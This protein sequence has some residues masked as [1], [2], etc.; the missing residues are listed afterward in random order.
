MLARYVH[1]AGADVPLVWYVTNAV[2]TATRRYLVADRQGSIV[3]AT[4][5]AGAPL[6]VDTY[7]EYGVPGASNSGRFQY[8]G[9]AW[10]PELGMYYYKA[11]VYSPTL[12]RFMQT[13]PIGYADQVNLYAYVGDDP[14]NR[15]DPTGNFTF[16]YRGSDPEKEKLRQA[17]LAA[18]AATPELTRRYQ[19]MERSAHP[20]EVVPMGG[21]FPRPRSEP[22][23]DHARENSQNG[24]GT[25]SQIV[26]PLQPI[27]LRGQGVGGSDITESPAAV[28]A[29]EALGHSYEDDQGINT[30]PMRDPDTGRTFE[31]SPEELRAI[32]IENSYHNAVHEPIRIRHSP[33]PSSDQPDDGPN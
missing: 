31:F 32:S 16:V 30:E 13:D 14:I 4:S 1:G 29:H 9:Q 11:R 15:A 3:V 20:H 27:V 28:A 25:G 10:L 18:A 8:T 22:V 33:D 7:D 17:V 19:I 12:G 23:G 2:G 26:L 24:V 5:S 6:F 21:I